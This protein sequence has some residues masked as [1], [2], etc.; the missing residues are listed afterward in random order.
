MTTATNATA[1]SS[2]SESLSEWA[3]EL[4]RTMVS[5]GGDIALVID[6][7]GVVQRVDQRASTPLASNAHTWVGHLWTE[8][9]T[10]E[11]KSKVE[12]LM[13]EASS[14]CATRKREVNH[15]ASDG[16]TVPV[17]YTAMRLGAHGP[18]LAVGRDLGISAALQQKFIGAQKEMERNYAQARQ[19]EARY[20]LLFQVATDAVI[21][22]DGSTLNIIEANQ[23]ASALFDLSISQVVGQN[24]GFGFE[25]H[26]RD[27]VTAALASALESGQS[28]ETRAQLLGRVSSTSVTATPFR[29]LD[30]QQLLVRIR[31]TEQLGSS[32]NLGATLARLV[33]SASDGVAV[34]DVDGGVLVANP[35]FLKLV[36]ASTEAS[37]RGRPLSDWLSLPNEPFAE[38]LERVSREGM[39]GYAPSTI[40]DQEAA[41]KPVEVAATLLGEIDPPCIGFSI[42]LVPSPGGDISVT[43]EP[44]QAAVKVLCDQVGSAALPEL[45]RRALEVL[46]RN[47]I[48]MAMERAGADLNKAATMLGINRKQLDQ[49]NQSVSSA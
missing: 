10:R 12:R 3:P 21:V 17:A 26:S 16:A 39:T 5:L 42:R 20:R 4:A 29:V 38:L 1:A 37:V 44:M 13:A 41:I 48:R 47:F 15:A 45:M 14:T 7:S 2:F 22:V 43:V 32:A 27:I 49:L 18:I 46:Q 30:S 31:T 11:S 40:L 8:T 25:R 23:S 9:V 35:A 28:T 34:T 19:A 33:D 36:Q 24:A 6:E